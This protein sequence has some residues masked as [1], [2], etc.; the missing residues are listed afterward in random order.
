MKHAKYSALEPTYDFVP[1]AVETAGPWAVEA[2]DFVVIEERQLPKLIVVSERTQTKDVL[3]A[4]TNTKTA[5][6]SMVESQK[7]KLKSKCTT[8]LAKGAILVSCSPYVEIARRLRQDINDKQKKTALIKDSMKQIPEVKRRRGILKKVLE[9]VTLDGMCSTGTTTHKKQPTLDRILKE[10]HINDK[11]KKTALIKDSMKQI[12]EVKRRRGILKKVLEDVTLD[13]M[14]STGTTTHK[15][16][17]TLDRILKESHIFLKYSKSCKTKKKRVRMDKKPAFFFTK[18]DE[19][20]VQSLNEASESERPKRVG[21]PA[22]DDKDNCEYI[23]EKL[24][25]FFTKRDEDSVQSFNEALESERPK[26]VGLPASDDNDNC[27]YIEEKLALFFT[28]RE[29]DSVQSLNEA[30]E[31]ERPVMWPIFRSLSETTLFAYYSAAK[32]ETDAHCVPLSA[33]VINSGD[34]V[35]PPDHSEDDAS[36]ERKPARLVL[37]ASSGGPS[38][39]YESDASD[40]SDDGSRLSGVSN[41]SSASDFRGQHLAIVSSCID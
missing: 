9:D 22:S 3:D 14:C 41:M 25:F 12:P 32:C 10:S 34:I 30:S 36:L 15:K 1:V 35:I 24:A 19:D 38:V 26:R 37:R 7:S 4:E 29:K 33:W 8:A 40:T 16:Q 6:F 23:E 39:P 18:R 11:Q 2:R 13:G 20:S 17:P 5:R 31:N 21:L 28:K 27:E